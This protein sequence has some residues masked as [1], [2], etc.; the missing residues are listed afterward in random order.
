MAGVSRSRIEVFRRPG[1]SPIQPDLHLLQ[2]IL[3]SVDQGKVIRIKYHSNYKQKSTERLVEPMG[4][5]FT[6]NYWHLIGWC[7]LRKDYRDFKVT[8]IVDQASPPAILTAHQTLVPEVHLA[9]AFKL[10][11]LLVH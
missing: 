3:K 4:I 9:F 1:D 10:G 7:H 8:S 5:F 2:P 6:D 11:I